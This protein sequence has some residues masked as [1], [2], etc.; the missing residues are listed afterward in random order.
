MNGTLVAV[1]KVVVAVEHVTTLTAEVPHR[2]NIPA[3]EWLIEARCVI[4]HF[5]HVDDCGGVPL[6][7]WLI[8]GRVVCEHSLSTGQATRVR[9]RLIKVRGLAATHVHGIDFGRV[10][11]LKRLIV[12]GVRKEFLRTQGEHSAQ[13][14]L[15]TGVLRLVKRT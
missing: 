1:A 13:R 5:A 6:L 10:P 4:K 9:E 15:G 11:L 7:E 14:V 8:E 12:S 3:V 2:R